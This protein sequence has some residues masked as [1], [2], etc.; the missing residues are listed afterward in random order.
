MR[1]ARDGHHP[2]SVVTPTTRSSRLGRR[3]CETVKCSRAAAPKIAY[4]AAFVRRTIYM[5]TAA[6]GLFMANRLMPHALNWTPAPVAGAPPAA[7]GALHAVRPYAGDG[8][9]DVSRDRN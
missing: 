5:I 1:L 9:T 6:K 2:N 8:F 4:V 3:S 7:A